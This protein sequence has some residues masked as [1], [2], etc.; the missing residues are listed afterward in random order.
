MPLYRAHIVILNPR[1]CEALRTSDKISAWLTLQ[2][3]LNYT[4]ELS[5]L[6]DMRNGRKKTPATVDKTGEKRKKLWN[7][8]PM[9]CW[10]GVTGPWWTEGLLYGHCV[11]R[12]NCASI[13]LDSLQLQLRMSVSWNHTSK[14]AESTNT[15]TEMVN[16]LAVEREVWVDTIRIHQTYTYRL[17]PPQKKMPR[18]KA[19]KKP[20]KVWLFIRTSKKQEDPPCKIKLQITGLLTI[21]DRPAYKQ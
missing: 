8:T 17:G 5:N 10:E 3:K 15:Q 6:N 14:Q 2:K 9:R 1:W 20:S 7:E 13:Q 21:P 19:P 11:P 18:R 16:P 4:S 12:Y